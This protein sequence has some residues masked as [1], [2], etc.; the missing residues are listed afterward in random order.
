[1][2]GLKQ[3][4]RHSD[5]GEYDV[6]FY[7]AGFEIAL[8]M[9]KPLRRDKKTGRSLQVAMSWTHYISTSFNI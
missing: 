3:S 8:K 4:D 1:M 9:F 6:L 5:V 2:N 7:R